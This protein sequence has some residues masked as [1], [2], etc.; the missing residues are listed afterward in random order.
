VTDPRPESGVAAQG[1]PRPTA[2]APPADGTPAPDATDQQVAPEAPPSSGFGDAAAE[3]ANE[4]EVEEEPAG[5]LSEDVDDDLDRARRDLA[6]LTGDLQRLQAEFV[7]YKRRVDRDRD[8][9]RENATYAA[10]APITEVLD[11][12]DRAREHGPLED[13]GF[14]AVADQLERIVTGL[15]LTKFGAVGEPFDPTVHEALS[16]IGEDP[17]VAVT[18][19]KVI[20]KA[21][22]RIGD[23]VVRAAQVLVV[24]PPASD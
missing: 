18:T 17:D 13:D 16:H 10:L 14:R 3:M 2:E 23:R 11:T 22:Y 21:G 6:E 20:A 8:L 15:G 24:D 19:C 4:T 12:I 9:I 5:R 1:E 7:N